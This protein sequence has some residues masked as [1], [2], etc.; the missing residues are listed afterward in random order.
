MV[1]RYFKARMIRAAIYATGWDGTVG[2]DV[3]DAG[4]LSISTAP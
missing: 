2:L 4:E 1:R 3:T